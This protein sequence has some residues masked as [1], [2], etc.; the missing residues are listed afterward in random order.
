[1]P[2]VPDAAVAAAPR[3]RVPVP[4]GRPPERVELPAAVERDGVTIEVRSIR[5]W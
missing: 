3:A 1:V 2:G 4:R 5:S